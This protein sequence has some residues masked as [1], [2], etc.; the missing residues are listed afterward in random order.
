MCVHCVCDRQ[1]KFSTARKTRPWPCY[2]QT[3][4]QLAHC[5]CACKKEFQ[6]SVKLSRITLCQVLKTGCGVVAKTPDLSLSWWGS[7]CSKECR[8]CVTSGP[9]LK[10]PLR[11][12]RMKTWCNAAVFLVLVAYA[13]AQSKVKIVDATIKFKEFNMVNKIV[14]S[15]AWLYESIF[16]AHLDC[17]H[18]QEDQMSGSSKMKFAFWSVRFSDAVFVQSQDGR[19]LPLA[20]ST[21]N[22]ILG[23][24][25]FRLR[26]IF[27]FA[28]CVIALSVVHLQ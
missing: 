5:R 7:R 16:W 10:M 24:C 20:V 23:A 13:T 14:C 6:R 25:G 8:G 3:P 9:P 21:W 18:D 11:V 12:G 15:H 22:T 17:L 2:R 28:W 26:N 4:Q 1:D 19:R 27:S